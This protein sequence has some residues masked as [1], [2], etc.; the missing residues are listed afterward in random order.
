MSGLLSLCSGHLQVNQKGGN[1]AK[2]TVSFF[3][4]KIPAAVCGCLQGRDGAS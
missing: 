2:Q 3:W 1:T 4:E